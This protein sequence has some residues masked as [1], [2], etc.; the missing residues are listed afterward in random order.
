MTE[1]PKIPEKWEWSTLSVTCAKI[2]DGTHFSPKNQTPSGEFRYLTAKNVRPWGL[3]LNDVTYI[4]E[5]EHRP[6]YERCD[7]ILGDVLLVKDGVNTGDAAIYTLDEEASLL[8]SVCM[9]RPHDHAI[10][11]RYLRYYLMSPIGNRYLTGEM[12][13]T[14]IRRIILRRIRELPIPVAPLPEQRRIVA[15]IE[16]QFTRLD[17]AVAALERAQANLK[18]YRASVLAA[19]CEGRLVPTEAELA[20]QETTRRGEPRVRPVAPSNPLPGKDP[21][22]G[23]HEVRPYEPAADLL[24]RILAERQTRWE[25]DELAKLQARGKPPKNDAWKS[26]YKPP[27]EPDSSALPELPEGWV[28]STIDSLIAFGPQNGLY[29]PASAYGSGTPIIR[30]DDYQ[31]GFVK[32][33]SS[34]RTLQI[35][36][37]ERDRYGLTADEILINRVN[38]VPQLGKAMVVRAEMCPVVFESNMMRLRLAQLVQPEWLAFYIWSRAGRDR[39][40]A[41]AK[42]AVNQASINQSDVRE[43]VVPLPPA[44][45]QHRIVAEV[46]RRLS[47]VEEMERAVETDLQRAGRLRQAILKRAFE[48]RLVPQDPNDEPASALLDRIRAERDTATNKGQRPLP[49]S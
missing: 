30:I 19:A 17:A 29:K 12:S 41:N 22:P 37:D 43:T 7:V 11:N 39:L 8:S 14:A 48:G 31:D 36:D 6:I 34:L 1:R 20:S 26:K 3:D 32:D 18:R 13:G 42:W 25:A 35:N 38:S 23:E 21:N 28:W 24:D 27:V 9:L 5:T 40:I 16:K 49:I 2:Q 33:R 46:E 45:E 4:Q 47:V 10:Q 44:F 15:E